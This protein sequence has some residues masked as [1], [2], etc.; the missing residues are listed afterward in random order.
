MKQRRTDHLQTYQFR[1]GESGNPGGRPK[2]HLVTTAVREQMDRPIPIA[3]LNAMQ[4][5]P[6]SVF[7]EVYGPEPTFAQMIAFKLVQSSAR[8]EMCALKVLLDRTE[9][10]VN[11]RTELSSERENPLAITVTFMGRSKPS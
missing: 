3:M 8:G 11:Q 9:G 10:K 6:R 7:L 4:E 1:P 5:A 2:K